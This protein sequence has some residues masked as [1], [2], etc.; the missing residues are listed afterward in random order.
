MSSLLYV[1]AIK[2]PE[3]IVADFIAPERSYGYRDELL[4]RGGSLDCQA[5]MNVSVRVI[6]S[7]QISFLWPKELSVQ[8]LLG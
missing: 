5:I 2:T 8:L 7:E 1:K 6:N 4:E 3:A